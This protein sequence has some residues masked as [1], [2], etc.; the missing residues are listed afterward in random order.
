[1]QKIATTVKEATGAMKESSKIICST[2]WYIAVPVT[3]FVFLKY[4]PSF[5]KEMVEITSSTIQN[6]TL[7]QI[8]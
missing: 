5:V 7:S 4:Y 1:M 8:V 3:G 6:E 2:V